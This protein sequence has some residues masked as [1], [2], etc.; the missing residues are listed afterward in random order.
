MSRLPSVV[1]AQP[2]PRVAQ[3]Q[4]VQ[5]VAAEVPEV[6]HVQVEKEKEK[7]REREK[8]KEKEKEKNKGYPPISHADA[9]AAATAVAASASHGSP[10]VQ[11][12]SKKGVVTKKEE[13]IAV[14]E[15]KEEPPAQPAAA[16]A[17]P[18]ATTPAATSI[19]KE[20]PIYHIPP[21]LQD[22]VQSF[23]TTKNR[24][25]SGW[26]TRASETQSPT[27]AQNQSQPPQQQQ[28][29][30]PLGDGAAQSNTRTT[31]TMGDAQATSNPSVS[32]QRLLAASHQSCPEFSDSEKPMHYRPTFPYDTPAHYPQEPLALFRDPRLFEGRLET[33][34]L[35]YIF[36]YQQ[37]T[38]Y[39]Y[40]AARSLKNESWRFHKQYQTW[41]Q[42]HEEPKIIT[43][44][45]E[46][47][48][49]RF[50][51]YESTWMNRRKADFQFMYKY[52]EDDI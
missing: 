13:T 18:A 6:A 23:E 46:Q 48:T 50:F 47:G 41:F 36:Y 10:T 44:E 29:Q 15:S 33:D 45:F 25:A 52:L 31:T 5:K 35:F 20:E 14:T 9:A 26:A 34:T 19:E 49:Y 42:R 38:Y 12:K 7:E 17:A 51:D 1:S 32:L 21:T 27:Y 3:V 39:Q 30:Q 11:A 22:L 40:L 28:Q 43:E 37:G 8:D 24:Y 4:P 16:A 2:S